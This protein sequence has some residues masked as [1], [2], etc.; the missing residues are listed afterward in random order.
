M[1]VNGWLLSVCRLKYHLQKKKNK[2][3]DSE[4][5]T[6]V[7]YEKYSIK[8]RWKRTWIRIF[9]SIWRF[10]NWQNTF[11]IMSQRVK[12]E[13]KL[14]K[15]KSEAKANYKTYKF[16]GL[17]PKPCDLIMSRLKLV[18][19]LL[20]DRTHLC[21]N[22]VGWLVIRGERLIKHGDSWLSAKRI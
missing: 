6:W 14:K 16:F 3:I 15:E 20:E 4:L 12:Q 2:K 17:N 7:K 19:R 11:C 13:S 18:K 9:K 8:R 10:F 1:K 21:C 5:V 22:R